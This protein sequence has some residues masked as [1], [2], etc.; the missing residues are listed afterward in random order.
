MTTPS[1]RSV[2]VV[3]SRHYNIGFLGV[4]RLH[5]FDSRKYGRAWAVL[6]AELGP[7]LKPLHLAVPRQVR[8]AELELVHSPEYLRTLRNSDCIAR[9]L[10]LPALRR[11]PAWLLDWAVL[12]PMRWAT[13]GTIV[14]ARAAL[15]HGIAINLS[16]GYHHAKPAAGEGFC[17]YSDIALAIRQL[18][19]EGRLGA[20]DR[21]A[22]ID[23]DAHQG[24]GVC[25]QFM[26]DA[27]LFAFDMYNESVYPCHD[28]AAHERID[29]DLP[30][31]PH[32]PGSEYLALLRGRLGP[33]LDS[34][35]RSSGLGLAIYNAGSDVW[36]ADRL[37]GLDLSA[38]DVLERDLFVVSELRRRGLP[39]VMLPSGGYCPESYRLLARSVLALVEKFG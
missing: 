31:R 3:Y 14:A 9:V 1:K 34:V 36:T 13:M 22:Y 19:I 5:P 38:D 10:E 15:E 2:R 16:G 23:L 17:V 7:R 8:P 21:I 24:N 30:L 27:T 25:H 28:V 33:F 20:A 26:D 18:R 12:R 32:C 37:G 39:T 4:E 29:C 6:R 11:V 35:G